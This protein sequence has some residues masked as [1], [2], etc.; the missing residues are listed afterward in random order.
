MGYDDVPG[1][2]SGRVSPGDLTTAMRR[3]AGWEGDR[4]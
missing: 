4:S 1:E 3:R 2:G